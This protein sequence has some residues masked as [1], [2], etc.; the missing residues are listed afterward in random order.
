MPD[1]TMIQ[2]C[3]PV[4]LDTP[5]GR[6]WAYFVRDRSQDHDFEWVCFQRDTGEQWTYRSRDVRLM[7]NETMGVRQGSIESDRRALIRSMVER[8]NSRIAPASQPLGSL[9][10]GATPAPA[11]TLAAPP[12]AAAGDPSGGCG[13]A[14]RKPSR[15][16]RAAPAAGPRV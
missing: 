6:A 11:P 15:P 10:S 9:S 2:C 1:S 3:P 13:K 5:R 4:P 12:P 14:S 8:H 7:V 16:R